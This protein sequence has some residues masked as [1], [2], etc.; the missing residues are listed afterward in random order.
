MG[1]PTQAVRPDPDQ[2]LE[3]EVVWNGIIDKQRQ[4]ADQRGPHHAIVPGNEYPLTGEL[5]NLSHG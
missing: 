4:T 2:G 1:L 3:Y 5:E